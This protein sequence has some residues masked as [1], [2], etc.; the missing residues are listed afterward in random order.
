MSYNAIREI[1]N[2]RENFRI[3]SSKTEVGNIHVSTSIENVF[4]YL[5]RYGPSDLNSEECQFG[6]L[7][8]FKMA[9]KIQDGHQ[10]RV[11]LLFLFF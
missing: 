8:Q 11:N 2:S 1:N 4:N 9:F 5:S 7:G 3:Y 6:T 10:S